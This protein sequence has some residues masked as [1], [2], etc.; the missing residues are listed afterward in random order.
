MKRLRFAGKR[1]ATS[2]FRCGNF[3][4]EMFFFSK[5][6]FVFPFEDETGKKFFAAV[7]NAI[8]F[9]ALTRF[10]LLETMARQRRRTV[11]D[12]RLAL[13]FRLVSANFSCK[14]INSSPN[15]MI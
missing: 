3:E 2:V 7:G 11:T 1:R 8:L 13:F 4:P 6:C 5:L 12:L 10:F 15:L 14:T 9:E